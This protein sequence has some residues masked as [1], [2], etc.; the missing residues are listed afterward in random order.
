MWYLAHRQELA[1]KDALKRTVFDDML[2][3]LY[4][5]YEKSSKNVV[6]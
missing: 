1:L 2:I 5:V 4:Y 6:N 3:R